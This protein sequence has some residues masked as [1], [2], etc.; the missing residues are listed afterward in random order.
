[1]SDIFFGLQVAVTAAPNDDWRLELG[2]LI[3]LHMRDLSMTDK[4]N[5]YG[6]LANMLMQACER[7]TFGFWDM[8]ED[9]RSKFDEWANG[10][11][12]DHK[13]PWVADP[14]GARMDQILVSAV[15]LLPGDG[16]SA[17]LVR[18][19][20]D[21]PE[22]QW[23]DRDTYLHLFETISQLNFASV[24]SDAC[25]ITPGGNDVAFPRQELQG[26]GYDYLLAMR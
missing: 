11:E 3:R 24:R 21:L 4:R 20:C 1:M 25:Y 9:G 18:Q 23:Q 12:D 26:E 22:S 7:I 19:R 2:G 15:F 6:S 10:I 17:E 5:F 14:S 8:I 13:E 16:A